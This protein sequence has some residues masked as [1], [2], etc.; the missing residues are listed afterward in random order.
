[1]PNT[2]PHKQIAR[3]LRSIETA[4]IALI[5]QVSDVFRGIQTGNE[6]EMTEALGGLVAIAYYMGQQLG[7]NLAG[8][9]RQA[10]S[11]LPQG[12]EYD[13]DATVDFSVV[14]RYLNSR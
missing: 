10:A 1:M 5:Q 7:L 11:G 9:D 2:D 4:K 3:K 6:R 13:A 14:Q 12:L 8:V